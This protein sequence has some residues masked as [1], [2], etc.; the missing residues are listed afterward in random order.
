MSAGEP[1]D[2]RA[3]VRVVSVEVVV[4]LLFVALADSLR[5][6]A[7]WADDGPQAGYFPFYVGALMTV[8]GAANAFIAVRRRWLGSG[9]FV[10]R[11]GLGHVL[12][13]LVPTAIFAAL[14]GW[15]GLYV[16]AAIFIG[17]FMLWHGRFR[18]YSAAA[19][20]LGVPLVLFLVFERWFLVPLPKGPLEAMLG[21]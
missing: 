2:H 9:P 7:G 10:S 12:H 19:V 6:G 21:L 4:A 15:V 20:A 5:V 17:W 11:A 1:E 14:I 8:A 3:A 18:W 13:V 16:A